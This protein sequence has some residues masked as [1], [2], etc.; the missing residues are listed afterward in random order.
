MTADCDHLQT[1][2]LCLRCNLAKE[3]GLCLKVSD[4]KYP[5]ERTPQGPFR[6]LRPALAMRDDPLP[7]QR[8]HDV[9]AGVGP[10]E[11][12]MIWSPRRRRRWRIAAYLMVV[13]AGM[14]RASFALLINRCASA[15]L[16]SAP[17][18]TPRIS[19]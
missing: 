16:R 11:R 19:R 6:R 8:A 10:G 2:F 14:V 17:T 5:A 15:R 18:S 9:V 4:R 7:E 12:R 3:A 13:A 1:G